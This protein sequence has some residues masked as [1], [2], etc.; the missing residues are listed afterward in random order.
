MYFQH[1]NYSME[2][3]QAEEERPRFRKSRRAKAHSIL[4]LEAYVQNP[5]GSFYMFWRDRDA[6][7]IC[8]EQFI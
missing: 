1:Q 5:A 2:T 7:C 4:M 3:F 8:S 6:A